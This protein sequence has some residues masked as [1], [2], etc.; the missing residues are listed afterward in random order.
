MDKIEDMK[1]STRIF[2]EKRC[3]ENAARMEREERGDYSP[4]IHLV[5]ESTE[6]ARRNFRKYFGME[7][8]GG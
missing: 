6:E 4:F 7:P 1:T 5:T 3:S 8:K 2:A